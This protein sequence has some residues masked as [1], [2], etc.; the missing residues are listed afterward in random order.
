MPRKH[1]RGEMAGTAAL[2]GVCCLSAASAERGGQQHWWRG[3]WPNRANL[4]AL[5][6]S[7]RLSITAIAPVKFNRGEGQT[8]REDRQTG[9]RRTRPED[10]PYTRALHESPF[11][12][13]LVLCLR[14]ES[15]HTKGGMGGRHAATTQGF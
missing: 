15:T 14:E 4:A 5:R 9:G 10:A 11:T 2:S 8:S 13:S 12:A 1:N 3:T 7:F 6:R